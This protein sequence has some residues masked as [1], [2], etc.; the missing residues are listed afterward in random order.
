MC[1][2]RR[3]LQLTA[4]AAAAVTGLSINGS[5]DAA[6]YQTVTLAENETK[7]YRINDGETFEN[8]LFDI[9]A[10]GAYVH[11]IANK[12]SDWIIRNIGFRG[13]DTYAEKHNLIMVKVPSNGHGL[14]R[15]VYFGDGSGSNQGTP[16]F[17]HKDHAGIVDIQ[18]CYFEHW[19]DNAVYGSAPGY[20][21]VNPGYGKVRIDQ[22]YS[23]NNNISNFR[24]GTDGSYVRDSV[25]HV[26]GTVPGNVKN[27]RGIWVKEGGDCEIRNCDILLESDDGNYCVV[28]ADDNEAGIA[29]VKESEIAARNGASGRFYSKYGTITTRNVGDEPSVLVPAGVPQTAVT[30]AKDD[31]FTKQIA[32]RGG[33]R[34]QPFEYSFSTTDNIKPITANRNDYVES[35]GAIGQTTGGS[36][37]YYL[38]GMLKFVDANFFGETNIEIVIDRSQGTIRFS[39]G[40]KDTHLKYYVRSSDS[41]RGGGNL[42]EDDDA[43]CNWAKGYT[44]GFTD[45]LDYTGNLTAL[46]ARYPED[47]GV[48]DFQYNTPN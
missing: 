29:R 48:I 22:C 39:G 43:S 6:T 18:R 38:N 8:Y 16:I 40:E 35:N 5:A 28:E 27:A 45:T 46:W 7:I 2:R 1:K 23:K 14:I 17:V 47:G 20:D 12:T 3:Y 11:I 41:I 42:N 31:G 24:I 26:D 37:I 4:G 34:S 32:F 13:R 10:N 9:S 30:A 19:A 33:N 25:V 44:A 36:D 15:N 21:E